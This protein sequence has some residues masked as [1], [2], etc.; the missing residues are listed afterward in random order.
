MN[1]IIAKVFDNS[2][3]AHL[4]RTK[5]E[6]EGIACFIFDDNMISMNPLYNV[7]LGGIKLK[8]REEDFGRALEIIRDIDNS[9]ST[10]EEGNIIQCPECG[11]SDLYV[12]YKSMKGTKG[13]LSA[14]VSF[15]FM[16]FPIYYKTVYKCKICNC[17][18]KN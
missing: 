10:D 1:L 2:I 7:G 17:E 12:G 15:L 16:V 4:L 9:K 5:L 3:E 6:S 11:S 18:F 14:A 13:M 8:V